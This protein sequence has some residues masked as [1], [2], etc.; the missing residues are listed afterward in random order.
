M[1]KS[2][3]PVPISFTGNPGIQEEQSKIAGFCFSLI[4]GGRG[5]FI[6]PQPDKAV[7][8]HLFGNVSELHTRVSSVLLSAKVKLTGTAGD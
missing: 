2:P 6:H 7:S 5:Y 8:S 3:N 1:S 4:N